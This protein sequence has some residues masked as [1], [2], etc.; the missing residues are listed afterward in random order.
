MRGSVKGALA[1]TA[2]AVAVAVLPAAPAAAG[3]DSVPDASGDSGDAVDLLGLD[4]RH[5]EPASP[6]RLVLRARHAGLPRFEDRVFTT[7]T[8]WID[9]RPSNRGPEF[10]SDVVPNT[11]GIALRRVGG[12]GRRGERTVSC[13]GLRARADVFTDLPVLLRVPL[14]CLA[15]PRR[16]RAAV[17]AVGE[18]PRGDRVGRDWVGSRRHW[19]SW[20]RR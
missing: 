1:G 8:F 9:T 2:I 12:W 19:S 6:G 11:G 17:V 14:T 10:V 16:V 15:E 7:V 13:P 3:T 4:V 18:T 20:V 5:A